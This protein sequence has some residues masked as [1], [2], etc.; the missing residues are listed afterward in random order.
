MKKKI[1]NKEE[2]GKR[3]KRLESGR[4]REIWNKEEIGV[5]KK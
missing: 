5:E 2:K 3:R 4:K 1:I